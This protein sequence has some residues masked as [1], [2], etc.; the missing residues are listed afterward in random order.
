MSISMISATACALLAQEKAAFRV[1]C[2][3]DPADAQCRAELDNFLES[4]SDAGRV[5]LCLA[6]RG[7]YADAAN[8]ALAQMKERWLMF[9][10]PADY[11]LPDFLE[12]ALDLAESQEAEL[13][14]CESGKRHTQ[15][16][17]LRDTEISDL[18][19]I[20]SALP[21][22]SVFSAEE[23]K[24]D[25]FRVVRL[26]SRLSIFRV[27]FLREKGLRI[28]T[29]DYPDEYCMGRCAL[30]LAKR[31]CAQRELLAY[32]HR[33]DRPFRTIIADLEAFK[34]ELSDR[35]LY[36]RYYARCVQALVFTLYHLLRDARMD[37]E[38]CEILDYL[39]TE[40]TRADDFLRS[41]AQCFESRDNARQAAFLGAALRRYRS[42]KAEKVYPPIAPICGGMP[43]APV[44]S[45]IMPVFN[46]ERY[47]EQALHSVLS[48]TLKNIEVLCIDDG[49]AD[50]S[51]ALMKRIPASGFTI[52]K[53]AV[54]PSP[55]TGAL[56]W[57]GGPM[58]TSWTVTTSCCPRRLRRPQIRPDRRIW[59]WFCS[60]PRIF[61]T[62]TIPTTPPPFG[63]DI[64]AL[65]Y[66]M[67]QRPRAV[68]ADGFERRHLLYGL[69]SACPQRLS[70]SKR[71]TLSRGDCL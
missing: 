18:S 24:R 63:T 23:I 47:V 8:L 35:G 53:T 17:E 3:V 50:A 46:T 55:E 34:R 30:V 27:D 56:C 39:N 37:A 42:V 57:P 31:I 5:S 52:R 25:L 1:L 69:A 33:Q 58:S 2:F 51:L 49:S 60:A 13:V 6:S 44:V 67:P 40:E 21:S 16:G 28:P 38:R 10:D 14:I 68:H 43:A 19:M 59:S 11:L 62:K 7:E 64:L 4:E 65:V 70:S 15:T 9:L 20:K 36:E 54:S 48:Q 32:L 66:A 26:P 22:K 12:R 45:V 29:L 61:M 71:H 41:D